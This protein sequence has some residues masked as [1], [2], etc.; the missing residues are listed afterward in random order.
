M[1]EC[2]SFR[3]SDPPHLVTIWEDARENQP[4]I[5]KLTVELLD[6]LVFSKPYFDPEG[7]IV[8]VADQQPVGFVHAGFG[9]SED[10]SRLDQRC[11]VISM[12]AVQHR[13]DQAN[14][15]AQL[16]QRGEQYLHERGAEKIYALGNGTNSPFYTG[17][18][19]GS[20]LPGV[21]MSDAPRL[22]TFRD[23]GYHEVDQVYVY[24]RDLAGFRP[25]VDRVQL[26]LRRTMT[27][28]VVADVAPSSW[29]EACTKSFYEQ[30]RAQMRPKVGG[31]C[32]AT[33]VFWDMELLAASW[34]CR[35]A[36][37][38]GPIQVASANGEPAV[39]HVL[40]GEALKQL[41]EKGF[42]SVDGQAAQNDKDTQRVFDALGMPQID[43]GVVLCK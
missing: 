33:V 18:Y 22:A 23:Q 34:D 40:V 36:L 3:N 24:R 28:E 5:R 2:R 27:V 17:L 11:G 30:I 4:F 26:Q 31:P 29:W 37:G 43:T 19:G 1:V 42:A 39:A 20:D 14:I 21:L 35:R 16:L 9:P 13:P 10:L 41:S 25:K 8:A 12:L 7:L 38:V 15:S 6:E 32:V